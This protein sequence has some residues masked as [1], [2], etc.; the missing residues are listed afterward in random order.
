MPAPESN[1]FHVNP[2]ASFSLDNLR[3]SLYDFS[4]SRATQT[5]TYALAE[6]RQN[7]AHLSNPLNPTAE[8][9]P[10]AEDRQRLSGRAEIILN[11]PQLASQSIKLG[12]DIVSVAVAL[13]DELHINEIDAGIL[14]YEARTNAAHRPDHDVVNAARDLFFLRRRESIWYL[15]EILRAGLLT[16]SDS[17]QSEDE[18]FVAALMR[19]RDLL[20]VDHQLFEN[21]QRRLVEGMKPENR[22][23][24]GARNPRALQRGEAV[25]LAETLFLLAY[26]VQ[27]TSSEALSLRSL[28]DEVDTLF[29]VMRK[30]E[31]D[32]RR[33]M[34]APAPFQEEEKKE[35]KGVGFMSAGLVEVESVRNLVFL[36]WVCAL[37]RSRYHDL[38]D[39]RSGVQG[40]NLLLKDL[41]FISR[42]SGVP[43]L[44]E[45]EVQDKVSQ[46]SQV[47][48]AAELCGAVFRLAVAMPD[49]DE[50][51]WTALRVSAFGGALSFLGE[52]LADWIEKRAGSICPD[53]DLYA[54]VVEDLALDV[55]EA[56][57]LVTSIVQF[58]Q[59]EVQAAAS[60]AAYA[61][62]DDN[63]GNSARAAV[64]A[65]P[66]L[67]SSQP[68]GSLGFEDV[69]ATPTGN[70]RHSSSG[71]GR[72]PLPPGARSIVRPQ[73]INLSGFRSSFSVPDNVIDQG[74]PRD[75][76]SKKEVKPKPGTTNNLMVPLANF[77]A[78]AVTLAPSKLRTDSV[79]GG[80]RYWSGIGPSSAGVIQ[81]IG[82]AV[83][84]L[85]DASMRNPFAPGGVG[86]AFQET[87]NAFL[88][89]LASTAGEKGSP[90]HASS[91]LRFLR[92]SGQ[93]AV[94][95][96]KASEALAHFIRLL[97]S[98]SAVKGAQMDIAEA[99]ALGNIID[100]VANA[101]ETLQ[102]H[103]GIA[104]LLGD[105]GKEFAMRMA[106]LATH[107]IPS[108]L[109]DS[110]LRAISGLNNRR[111]ISL[112]L[113][114]VSADNS[115]PLRRFLRSAESPNGAYQSSIQ[116]LVLASKV[117]SWGDDEFPESAVD[118]IA[119]WFA[120][121]EVLTF[122][123]RRKYSVEAHRWKIVRFAANLISQLIQ[124]NP[125]SERSFRILAR[126]LTPAP[127]T[128]AASFALRTLVCAA[129]LMRVGDGQEGESLE[130]RHDQASN[131]RQSAGL[132]KV[133]GRK[134]LIHAAEH[135]LGEAY[136][137]MQYA[138]Q[139]AAR[140]ISLI[141]SVPS[142]RIAVP[143]M[144][145]AP[146]SEL[147]FGEVK[148]LTS[149]ASLVFAVN[150]FIPAIAR[151]GYVP[152]VCAA[153]LGMLAKAALE[154]QHLAGIL[155]RDTPSTQG[156]AAEFRTSLA[157]IVARP[158]TEHG[159][160]TDRSDGVEG[161]EEVAPAV[162]DPP[163]MLSAL[164]I[165]EASLGTEGGSQ[166]GMALLGLKLN[167][168]GQYES[169]DYGVLGALVELVAGA[170]DSSGRVDD[171]SR[172]T[173]A[174]F[175]ER[176]AANT[177]R[178]TSIAVLEHLKE[179]AG[180]D[181]PR[182]RGGGFADEMLFRI[183]EV[184]GVQE[185][186]N[187]SLSAVDWNALGEL[188]TACMSLSALQVRMFPKNELDRCIGTSRGARLEGGMNPISAAHFSNLPSPIDLLKLLAV[189]SGSGEA[190]IAFEGLRTWAH[191]L[192]TRLSVHDR[193]TGYTRVP[194]LFELATL[195][196]GSLAGSD[197][198]SDLS[199]LV[200]KDGGE[201]ASSV[202]LLCVTRM[203]DCDNPQDPSSEEY[204]GD[205]Q[206]TS[207]I[208]GIIRAIA[209]I[210]GFSANAARARTSLYATVLVCG[211][212]SQGRVSE[213]ALNR[214]FG[215]RH[216]PRNLSG[217]EVLICAACAD[218]VSGPSP[219][220]KAAA[221]AAASITTLL[222][223]LRCIMA[224][225]SQ[226]RLRKV[227]QSTLANAEARQSIAQACSS[228]IGGKYDTGAE[229]AKD[230]ATLIVAESAL[231][232]IRAISSSGHGARVAS[233]SGYIEAAGLLLAPLSRRSLRGYDEGMVVMTGIEDEGLR[234][235]RRVGISDMDIDED[236]MNSGMGRNDMYGIDGQRNELRRIGMR[237]EGSQRLS[238]IASVTGG[239]ASVIACADGSVVEATVKALDESKDALMD[240]LREFRSL[241]S[242]DLEA[243][244]NLG[245]I[246]SK[247]PY[248]DMMTAGSSTQLRYALAAVIERV[249]PAASNSYQI[250]SSGSPFST[251]FNLKR[252][253][254]A[255]EGRRSRVFH[256]EGGSLLERDLIQER[257]ICTQNVLAALRSP[258]GVLHLFSPEL[259]GTGRGNLGER[260]EGGRVGRGGAFGGELRNIV[261]ICRAGIEEM[262]RSAEESMQM[263]TRIAGETGSSISSR[264]VNELSG[265][266]QE[267]YGI[268]ASRLNGEKVI[269]CLKKSSGGAREHADV[270]I[271]IV[272]GTLFI[273]REYVR[274]GR[275]ATRG[276]VGESWR[277]VRSEMEGDDRGVQ[278]LGREEG[279]RLVND[280]RKMVVPIC[281]EV[282]GLA[283]GVWGTKDGGFCRQLCRQIRTACS[284]RG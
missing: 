222:D 157:S 198:G 231:S 82:D 261:R 126:L 36:A 280:A 147:L 9:P 107:D 247:I 115:S 37:D 160:I 217:A 233:E 74:T 17:Q 164:R 98:P 70:R 229:S 237:G 116:V 27:L 78:H 206:C 221:M 265:F 258:A 179:V 97:E 4:Q 32:F 139:V 49:E 28:L 124:R 123:S 204:I 117:V 240:V 220:A 282:E 152:S 75:P 111:A 64:Q 20:V 94:S 87:L 272:E 189:I 77:I 120:S 193:N 83:I 199:G 216:G 242:D 55:A 163:V 176:L 276:E 90:S 38:Y 213:E 73:S 121:E 93:S 174:T 41:A 13:S 43:Q 234:S 250:G 99:N 85:W 119:T 8:K 143:G 138:A 188:L 103:G 133:S 52:D 114:S 168:S 279:E 91:A 92:D 141:L 248:G 230:K 178:R 71:R 239:I 30:E 57:Q 235:R 29:N 227:V 33:V 54:D 18:N 270:C 45:N 102:P 118:S 39:P 89:L 86:E 210:V 112:F 238:V 6:I 165:V 253:E 275:D 263:D 260:R 132:F 130:G 214:V 56:P 175:L 76:V 109:K 232:L 267:E 219:A 110:L 172:S 53:T 243:V 252:A 266:C 171:K 142:G 181:D 162:V 284:S 218:A 159:E 166:P 66:N 84:D 31:E 113:E 195:L 268:E 136:R 271:G 44:D 61:T 262:R 278:A 187:H 10:N 15:Q 153:I 211:F 137:E 149:A 3:Q 203:L 81:Q 11:I 205:M 88:R 277:K 215:G 257:A 69:H 129:G 122:W 25:L 34:R 26:T 281:K 150:G 273:L 62:S 63:F 190:Q 254:N 58:T 105:P 241:Q 12:P 100:V 251:G 224:F 170:H 184:V 186:A 7:R 51:L 255:R 196:L 182:I 151:A 283:G 191:L 223:P 125:T 192:G 259:G 167:T 23:R 144:V 14:L 249:I 200:K 5:Q 60:E 208:S 79:G 173:A 19:E 209:S 50:A 202:L 225:G 72:P 194:I 197:S 244:G 104:H 207:L 226:S 155:A 140:L 177:V 35:T 21:V 256:P 156:S 127:G 65:L 264:R 274:S 135:G 16:G 180:P 80:L 169:A 96:E 2:S 128:G 185:S 183:L 101:A 67:Q 40:V 95:L 148:A 212:L 228:E 106:S 1:T 24:P 47:R 246:I 134:A 108:T 158:T 59:N 201:M 131:D 154:S 145:V 46:M 48:A 269:D 68:R 245:M 42:T 146:A 161:D 236:V 22:Q